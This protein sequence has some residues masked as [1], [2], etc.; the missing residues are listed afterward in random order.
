MQSYSAVDAEDEGQL[1]HNFM[2]ELT[3]HGELS[4]EDSSEWEIVSSDAGED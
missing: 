1:P 2:A 4:Q 3:G